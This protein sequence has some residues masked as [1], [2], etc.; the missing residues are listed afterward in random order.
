MLFRALALVRTYMYIQ[1]DQSNMAVFFSY[2]VKSDLA[3]FNWST[4]IFIFSSSLVL[5]D[6]DNTYYC[7]DDDIYDDV[8]VIYYN[9]F[10]FNLI[11]NV[12]L[13]VDC[14]GHVFDDDYIN[15]QNDIDDDSYRVK[16]SLM[17]IR[18]SIIFHDDTMTTMVMTIKWG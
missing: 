17:I 8:E 15:H 11:I 18:V 10:I 12:K 5:T 6:N 14:V 13:N 2:L 1:G 4:Y 16:S 7:K 3:M 9:Y